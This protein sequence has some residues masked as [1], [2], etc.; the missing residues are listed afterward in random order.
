MLW[1]AGALA[2]A[3]SFIAA[4]ISHQKTDALVRCE[5]AS[6]ECTPFSTA[7]QQLDQARTLA[8]TANWLL[9]SGAVLAVGGAGLFT[10]DLVQRGKR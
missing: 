8:T 5:G 7:Q 3:G 9:G 4:G 6:R 10:F 1:S 2:L